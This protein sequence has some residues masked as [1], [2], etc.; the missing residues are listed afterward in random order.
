MR[1][2]GQF[3]P[4]Y[5]PRVFKRDHWECPV[6]QDEQEYPGDKIYCF[7]V[8]VF[9]N[10]FMFL[11]FAYIYFFICLLLLLLLIIDGVFEFHIKEWCI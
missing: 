11:L 9:L 8:V 10:L 4:L 3:K 1:V 7:F 2:D 5:I 6:V